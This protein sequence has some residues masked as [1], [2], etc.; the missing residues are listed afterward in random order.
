MAGKIR[1][2]LWLLAVGLPVTLAVLGGVVYF[3][4]THPLY[5]IASASGV[6]TLLEG[7]LILTRGSKFVC[8]SVRPESGDVVMFRHKAYTYIKR[9]VG[10]PGDHIQ[11]KGGV[12]LINGR[13]ASQKPEGEMKLV[14]SG[15][16]YKAEIARETLPNGKNYLISLLDRKADPEN[17]PVFTLPAGQYF[18]AG[19]SRDN[20]LDSRFSEEFDG[21]GFVPAGNICAVAERVLVSRDSTHAWKPL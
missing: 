19:D 6:P 4:L 14:V 9:L 13:P 15:F 21:I 10:L 3:S 20:S 5:S 1:R 7:D 11:F 12:L 18:V 16:S 17:T 2:E 8:G